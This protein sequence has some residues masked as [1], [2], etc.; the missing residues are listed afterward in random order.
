M[1]LDHLLSKEPRVALVSG[2]LLWGVCLL[3]V[4]GLV[5]VCGCRLVSSLW[6]GVGLVSGV[7]F[8]GWIVDR[9]AHCW[10]SEASAGPAR[11]VGWWGWRRVWSAGVGRAGACGVLRSS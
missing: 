11:C 1:R 3:V 10:G 5:G 6:L 4:G 8:C 2:C 7:K 9:K